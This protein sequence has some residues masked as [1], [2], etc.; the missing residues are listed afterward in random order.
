M[1][2]AQFKLIVRAFVSG[3]TPRL[4]V[5]ADALIQSLGRHRS[6]SPKDLRVRKTSRHGSVATFTV[7]QSFGS[8]ALRV[9]LL[10]PEETVIS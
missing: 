2:P 6:D 7:A 9:L 4:I 5:D 10:P 3:S 1:A 8:D